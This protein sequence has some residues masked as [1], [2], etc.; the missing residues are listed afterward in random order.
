MSNINKSLLFLKYVAVSGRT[1]EDFGVLVHLSLSFSLCSGFLTAD[2]CDCRE[3]GYPD[4]QSRPGIP[5]FLLLAHLLCTTR[6]VVKKEWYALMGQ[7]IP[8]AC[9]SNVCNQSRILFAR[10]PKNPV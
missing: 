6:Y 10:K 3:G 9:Y 5:A 4:K 7:S 1:G 8:Q 2:A